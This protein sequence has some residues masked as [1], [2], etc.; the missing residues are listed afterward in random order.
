M[1]A[2]TE[3]I[4]SLTVAHEDGFL[5]FMDNQMRT[6]VEV[7]TGM[8]PDQNVISTFVVDDI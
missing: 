3:Q 7:L 2:G 6:S 1:T 8:L 5:R 4:Q